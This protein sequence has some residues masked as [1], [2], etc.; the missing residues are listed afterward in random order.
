[1]GCVRVPLEKVANGGSGGWQ[2]KNSQNNPQYQGVSIR[3][4]ENVC[5]KMLKRMCEKDTEVT[6]CA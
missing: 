1:M 6:W 2:C 4:E 3:M 5:E